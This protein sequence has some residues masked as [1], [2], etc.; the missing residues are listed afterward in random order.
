[1]GQGVTTPRRLAPVV[2]LIE[3]CN[4]ACSYCYQEDLLGRRRVMSEATLT[5]I[6][7]E[8]ARIR[9]GPLQ[10]LWFGGEPT[11]VGRRAFERAVDIAEAHLSAGGVRHAIQTNATLID[12]AWA[13]LLARHR[14]TVT[15]S[16]DG[17]EALH[18]HHR[19]APSGRGTHALTM[20]GSAALKRAGITPRAS[21][22][23]TPHALPHAEALVDWFAEAGFWEADFPPAGRF[24]GGRYELL[25]TPE[26]Y[27][28]FM[29][30]VFD[31]WLALGRTDFRIFAF[32]ASP[33]R[34]G[35]CRVAR[36]RTASS[37]RHARSMPPSATMGG[38]IRATSSLASL[39]TCWATS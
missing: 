9:S 37:R 3:S 15:V 20:A 34:C 24:V 21:C 12:D 23:L 27:G 25:V 26:Q 11:L 10:I 32:A 5:R 6:V 1:M 7:S 31:R 16:L 19:K 22:V 39:S 30:R 38:C 8:L 13:A 4:L 28:E 17:F 14:F 29:V 33:A 35:D 36:P 18:D 2:K